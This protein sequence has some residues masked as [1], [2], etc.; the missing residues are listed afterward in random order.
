[1]LKNGFTFTFG[2]IVLSNKKYGNRSKNKKILESLRT[3]GGSETSLASRNKYY[4]IITIFK[5]N[6]VFLFFGV[7]IRVEVILFI[8]RTLSKDKILLLPQQTLGYF[9]PIKR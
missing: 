7:G 1:M 4:N 9:V 2:T 6:L 8:P 3:L 5:K